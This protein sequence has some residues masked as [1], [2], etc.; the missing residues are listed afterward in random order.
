MFNTS[1]DDEENIKKEIICLNL[2]CHKY[3][4]IN[5]SCMHEI[6]SESFEQNMIA[7]E[8]LKIISGEDHQS[9]DEGESKHNIAD[10]ASDTQ[11]TKLYLKIGPKKRKMQKEHQ[12]DSDKTLTK[13][14]EPNALEV[15]D[16][17]S[18]VILGIIGTDSKET[19]EI[20]YAVEQQLKKLDS[21]LVKLLAFQRL[22]QLL[23]LDNGDVLDDSVS[24]LITKSI[25]KSS[26]SRYGFRHV[27]LPSELLSQSD[28][29]RIAK[30][31]AG[32]VAPKEEVL[33]L[34]MIPANFTGPPG[35]PTVPTPTAPMPSLS[36]LP[37]RA[38]LCPVERPARFLTDDISDC[39]NVTGCVIVLNS[40]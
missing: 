20:F 26:L 31:V 37:V 23:G 29:E 19:T 8:D 16:E 34:R 9:A 39:L 6:D 2:N 32:A 1:L 13:D 14:V 11:E 40:F 4:S 33:R 3:L 17:K 24:E 30:E 5:D 15:G 12:H 10:D 25:D 22:Q 38:T 18:D 7:D 21:R 28:M 35:V 27:A 36:A